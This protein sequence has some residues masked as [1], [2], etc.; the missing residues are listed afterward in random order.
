MLVWESKTEAGSDEFKEVV[1][2]IRAIGDRMADKFGVSHKKLFPEIRWLD[3]KMWEYPKVFQWLKKSGAKKVM[4]FGC[5]YSPF[6]Q[7]LAEN[8]FEVWGVDDDSTD[9]IRNLGLKNLQ[10]AHPDVHY[11][12]GDIRDMTEKFDAIISCSVVE[13]IP[14]IKIDSIFEKMKELLGENGKMCHIVDHYFPDYGKRMRMN[15]LAT[16]RQ[17]GFSADETMCPEHPDFVS[18]SMDK[19][20]FMYYPHRKNELNDGVGHFMKP[21]RREARIMIGDDV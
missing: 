11:Y 10:K 2:G 7:Y 21:A 16:V 5:G 6:P 20:D 18:K 4:D 8:G 17:L 13:H 12:V 3:F 9:Y 1:K 15:F 14:A 19:I